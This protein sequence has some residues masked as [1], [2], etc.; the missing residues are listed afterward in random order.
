MNLSVLVCVAWMRANVP[1]W[2]AAERSTDSPVVDLRAD[3]VCVGSLPSGAG[4]RVRC[5]RAGCTRLP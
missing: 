5:T 4:A 3:G 2:D 1:G